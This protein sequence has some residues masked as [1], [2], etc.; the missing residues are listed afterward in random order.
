MKKQKKQQQRLEKNGF[1]VKAILSPTVS[2]GEERL[3]FC[4]HSYNSGK[5]ITE[6]FREP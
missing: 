4:L 6:C 2:V 1:A 3:R 5:E